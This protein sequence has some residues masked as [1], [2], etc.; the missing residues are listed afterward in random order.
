MSTSSVA[1]GH[2]LHCAQGSD[3]SADICC[4]LALTTHFLHSADSA[5][6]HR[7]EEIWPGCKNQST[8]VL[9]LVLVGFGGHTT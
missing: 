2:F 5:K 6:G 7:K 9:P 4:L 3:G 1:T 8:L